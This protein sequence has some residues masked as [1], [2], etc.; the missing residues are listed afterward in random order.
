MDR[1]SNGNPNPNQS[2]RATSIFFAR[3]DVVAL[4][5]RHD[6][7]AAV[8]DLTGAGGADDGLDGFVHHRVGHHDL[9][10][11]LRQEAH[12]VLTAAVH[13]GVPLLAPVPADLGHGHPGDVQLSQ[14]FL[15][16]VHHVRSNDGLDE[17][18]ALSFNM[19]SRSA[20]NAASASSVSFAPPRVM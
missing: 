11:H 2:L 12:F 10:F 1:R 16:V 17:F 8:A 19:R 18:H 20:F 9:D 14:S 7:H 4:L 3:A 13:R 15:D 6:E 5:H